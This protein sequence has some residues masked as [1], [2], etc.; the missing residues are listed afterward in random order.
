VNDRVANVQRDTTFDNKDLF[1]ARIRLF[2]NS[3]TSQLEGLREGVLL[4]LGFDYVTPSNPKDITSWVYD[5]AADKVDITDN[6]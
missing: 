2:Y 6:R 4:E 3:V 1:S 5:Y